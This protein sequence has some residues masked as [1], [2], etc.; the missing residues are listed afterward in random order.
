MI[1]Y[2]F[3]NISLNVIYI[4]INTSTN[5]IYSDLSTL[6]RNRYIIIHITMIYFKQN[7]IWLW[8]DG[9]NNVDKEHVGEIEYLPSPGFPVQYFP[10]VGQPE[11]LA[12]M[13]ALQFKNVTRKPIYLQYE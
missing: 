13:V 8:C 5:K 10:F 7:Q 9:A 1:D 12:P 6:Q 11:Y 3:T 2:D 4:Y